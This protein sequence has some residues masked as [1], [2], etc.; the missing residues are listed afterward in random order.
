MV[1]VLNELFQ[2]LIATRPLFILIPDSKKDLLM[3]IFGTVVFI[4]LSMLVKRKVIRKKDIPEA[5]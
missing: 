2:N 3:N 1:G 4:L 5:I